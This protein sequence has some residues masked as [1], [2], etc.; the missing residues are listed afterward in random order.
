MQ[1]LRRLR[2]SAGLKGSTLGYWEQLSCSHCW[3]HD[4]RACGMLG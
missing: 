1:C 2:G 4:G 3:E